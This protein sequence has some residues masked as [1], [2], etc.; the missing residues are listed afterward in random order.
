M[1][2]GIVQRQRGFLFLQGLASP[3]FTRLGDRLRAQGHAVF[4]VNF[5]AGDSAFWGRRPAW[6][7]RGGLDALPRFLDSRFRAHRITDVILFG[8]RRPVHQPAIEL[9]GTHGAR[10]HVFEEGYLRPNW[11]TVERGGT[12]AHSALPRD[13]HW[14]REVDRSL[15][16]H[17][18][19]HPVQ[20][21]LGL[22]AGQDLAYRVCNA[23]NPL[24]FPG[25]RTHRP[26]A[27]P[28]EYAGWARRFAGM[29][30][31]ELADSR[32][33]RRILARK[34][35]YFLLPLQLNG[36]T[37]IVHHS[38]FRD[39]GEVI[40]RVLG[41]FARHAPADAEIVIKNHPLDTGL[42]GYPRLVARLRRAL[43]LHQRVHYIESGHLPS[44]LEHA[45]GT[46][47]VNSSVGMS[48]LHHGCPTKALASPIYDMPGLT[49][50]GSLEAFWAAPEP[51]DR[52]LFLAFR[53][54]VIHATQVNGDFFTRDGVALAV[55]GCDR[56]FGELSPLEALL[57]RHGMPGRP[58][59]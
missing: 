44:L 14:Y 30:L 29:P 34:A 24:A 21:P 16:R 55:A 33:I 51:P 28:V 7:Y 40:E 37:Q 42:H 39:M 48:A 58:A 53:N 56:M 19:G 3:L 46:V 35:R 49:F 38:P 45:G 15:P 52:D 17:G 59:A 18:E 57:R 20:V 50:R 4:R 26:H 27:A 22:R 6:N 41:S 54:T 12:N 13:P 8:D 9:A 43:D 23:L 10:V 25:Y 32:L 5:C 2:G 1:T 36:D 11:I 31:T 47:L